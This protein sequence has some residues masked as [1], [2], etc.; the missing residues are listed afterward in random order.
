MEP[1]G[2]EA[3]GKGRAKSKGLAGA[4]SEAGVVADSLKR[5]REAATFLPMPDEV[6]WGGGAFQSGPLERLLLL[7]PDW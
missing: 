1:L 3:E 4:A 2:R 7:R 5:S 6:G